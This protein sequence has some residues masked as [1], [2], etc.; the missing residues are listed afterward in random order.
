MTSKKSRSEIERSEIREY[1]SSSSGLFFKVKNLL[2]SHRSLYQKIEVIENEYFGKVLLLDGLV[3]TTEKD[4]FYY[5]EM[6]VHPAL[7]THPSPKDILII[8]GG[9]GGALKEILRY[10]VERL[11][12]VE[13]DSQVI[14]VSKNF[15]P[16]LSPGLEDERVELVIADGEEFIHKI[17]R[18]Y[19]VVLVDSSGP[20]GPSSR[21]HEENF[22]RD[23][24]NC[25]NPEGV[26]VTQSGS[27]F[28]HLEELK[29][30][31]IF[32]D[33]IFKI[34]CFYTGPVPSYPG[35][36][37]CYVYLSDEINPLKL[38]REPPGG[39]KYFNQE[40]HE[41]AFSLPNF[42]KDKLEVASED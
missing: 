34:T 12:L 41:K 4:E 2:Y 9:D 20:V 32:L 29:K 26:V 11:W 15:F 24:K 35:G 33:K 31:N 21:L 1:H 3:Q 7:I 13:I 37:W 27:P 19:D 23:L 16:W 18:K 5:H 17:N 30:K 6:L 40:I 42:L 36:V 8:G 10:P 14:E 25:L 22:Y 38:T 39:L 28:Y